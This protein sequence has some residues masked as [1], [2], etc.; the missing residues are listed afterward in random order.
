MD[1]H[2]HRAVNDAE[3]TSGLEICAVVCS[4][5]GALGAQVD[6]ALTDLGVTSDPPVLV[7]VREFD[8]TIEVRLGLRAKGRLTP[9]DVREVL[10]ICPPMSGE[11][12]LERAAAVV[13]TLADRAG[14]GDTDPDAPQLP[15]VIRV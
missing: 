13:L 6:E 10:D 8:G 9:G 2:L 4:G 14:T 5:E 1:Q 12:P 7:A 3:A 15:D 11:H